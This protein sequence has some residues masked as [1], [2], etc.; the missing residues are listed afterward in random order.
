MKTNNNEEEFYKLYYRKEST[1]R[2]RKNFNKDKIDEYIEICK[3]KTPRNAKDYYIIKNFNVWSN[4]EGEYFL[5]NN[6]NNNN[7]D[8]P[9]PVFISN[10]KIYQFIKQAH[11]RT[12]HS[13]IKRTYAEVRK[14]ANNVKIKDVWL[15]ISLCYYCQHVKKNIK[16][17]KKKIKFPIKSPI[18]SKCFNQRAQVDLIDVKMFGQKIS[19][20]LNYQDNLTKFC[21]LKPLKDKRVE[22][23]KTSLR[24]IFNL[25]GAPKILQSDNGG[26]FRGKLLT[27]YFKTFWPTMKWIKGKPYKVQLKELTDI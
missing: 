20:V 25:F 14:M 8:T 16:N 15:Y 24:E 9:P 3:Q 27:N 6:N 11:E 26:E 23:I 10:D 12:L 18:V 21:I 5:I 2:C 22:S 1:T 13:G 17:N 4:N 19:Y 7:I